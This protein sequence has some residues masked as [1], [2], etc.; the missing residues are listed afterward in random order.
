MTEDSDSDAAEKAGSTSQEVQLQFLSVTL[1]VLK[2]FTSLYEYLPSSIEIFK[3]IRITLE[4][5][6][7]RISEPKLVGKIQ[8]L[9][10]LMKNLKGEKQFLRIAAEKPKPLRLYEPLI[11][12]G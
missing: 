2:K 1:D 4:E 9:C 10:E 6:K 3:P 7:E 12:E 5:V 8:E 11:E